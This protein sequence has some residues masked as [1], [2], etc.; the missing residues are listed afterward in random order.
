MQKIREKKAM[1]WYLAC[2]KIAQFKFIYQASEAG[3]SKFKNCDLDAEKEWN[4]AENTAL[5]ID[6]WKR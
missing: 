1:W 2:R 3:D 4:L 6:P 5:K